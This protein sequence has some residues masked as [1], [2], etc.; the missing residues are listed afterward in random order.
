MVSISYT[1][2]QLLYNKNSHLDIMQEV[3]SVRRRSNIKN[4]SGTI[5]RRLLEH[6]EIYVVAICAEKM[7]ILR[8]RLSLNREES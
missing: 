7:V 4:L 2:I 6:H 3:T 8:F 1:L 5:V